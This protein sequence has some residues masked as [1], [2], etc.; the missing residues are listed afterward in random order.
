MRSLKPE[1]LA[2]AT[3]VAPTLL[4]PAVWCAEPERKLSSSA[5]FTS[6]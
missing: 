3:L 5:K 1:I 4:G 6:T 2:T